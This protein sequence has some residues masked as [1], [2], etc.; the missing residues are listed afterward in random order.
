MEK[1][2][3]RSAGEL[4]TIGL[5]GIALRDAVHTKNPATYRSPADNMLTQLRKA[6][7]AGTMDRPMQEQMA[8]VR[9][10]R[11]GRYP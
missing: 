8:I 9:R 1:I 11:R 3:A 6:R 5:T 7:G 4:T 10:F 2:K